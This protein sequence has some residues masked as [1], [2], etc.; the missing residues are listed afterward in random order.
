[1]LIA[2]VISIFLVVRL[3]KAIKKKNRAARLFYILFI[4]NWVVC[5]LLSVSFFVYLAIIN[6][7]YRMGAYP[8][9]ENQILLSSKAWLFSH[10]LTSSFVCFALLLINAIVQYVFSTIRKKELLQLFFFDIMVLLI[11]SFNAVIVYYIN[12]I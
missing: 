2:F 10:L 4:I 6:N 11:G 3:I 5:F 9:L 1:M 7:Y 12:M 8:E